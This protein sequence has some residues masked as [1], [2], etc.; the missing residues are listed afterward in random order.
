MT[1]P[2]FVDL[3][4][5]EYTGTFDCPVLFLIPAPEAAGAVR[6]LEL[7]FVPYQSL[8]H[9]GELFFISVQRP[10]LFACISLCPLE[11]FCFIIFF[12][13]HEY[14]RSFLRYISSRETLDFVPVNGNRKPR[15]H[16]LANPKDQEDR[17]INGDRCILSVPCPL[18]GGV[19]S[20]GKPL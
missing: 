7:F 10:A 4:L 6:S 19:D 14:D 20:S 12:F 5:M 15:A 16:L 8:Y 1:V 9:G 13:H 18:R 3:I 2:F 17:Q 11:H